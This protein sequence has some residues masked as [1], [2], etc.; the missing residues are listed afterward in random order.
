MVLFLLLVSFIMGSVIGSF[1]NVVIDRVPHKKS[2]VK[3]R[4]HCDFC[5]KKLV[6]FELIPIISYIFLHGKCRH[7][8]KTIPLRVLI[9]ELLTGFGYLCIL[10]WAFVTGLS[11]ISL[12]L[13]LLTFSVCIAIF[14]IDIEHRIIPDTLLIVLGII[15]VVTVIFS[16]LDTL[17][18]RIVIALLSFLVFFGLFYVTSGRGMG[19]GDVK[20]ALAI[21]FLLGFPGALVAFYTAF[22]TGAV[23][24]LIL[25]I[26]GRKK[27]KT[28]TIPFGPFLV[29]GILVAMF[30]S[31]QI[32]QYVSLFFH[33]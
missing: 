31:A 8:K 25:V 13:F 2:L 28:G 27:F 23:I 17:A 24:S 7:C 14:F 20:F 12:F 3:G 4:S 18:L 33:V 5:H 32:L 6:W 19:F 1:L 11:V 21:G 29:I 30:F 10:S 9:V 15:G 16:P 22:L 26:G